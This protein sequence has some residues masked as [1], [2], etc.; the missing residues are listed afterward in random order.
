M[1]DD[2]IYDNEENSC[3]YYYTSCYGYDIIKIK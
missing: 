3:L 2:K 1:N